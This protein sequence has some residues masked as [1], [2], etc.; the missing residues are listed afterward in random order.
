MG[1]RRGELIEI[2][3]TGLQK[4]LKNK[5]KKSICIAIY[6]LAD[7]IINDACFK[8]ESLSQLS[9][10]TQPNSHTMH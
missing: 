1:E 9:A 5:G 8:A 10:L 4:R 7:S 2:N 6:W 3:I